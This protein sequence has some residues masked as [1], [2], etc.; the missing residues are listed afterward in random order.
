[1]KAHELS[2][3][4]GRIDDHLVTEA[5]E[6]RRRFRPWMGTVAVAAA[7]CLVVTA[8]LA[9]PGAGWLSGLP[10]AVSDPDN[11]GPQPGGITD[12]VTDSLTGDIPDGAAPTFALAKAV[13]PS[14]MDYPEE[15]YDDQG[16]NVHLEW[17]KERSA[18]REM[19]KDYAD[20]L[21]AYYRAT[22]AQFLS[23]EEGEN[24]VY[25]PLNL[26]IALAMLAETTDGNSRK[27]ILDLLDVAD[28]ETLRARVKGLWNANYQDDGYAASV[29]ANSLW[30][31]ENIEYVQKTLNTIAENYYASTFQGEMGSADYNAALQAW[32]NENTG[33]LLKDQAADIKTDPRT[34]LALASTIYFSGMWAEKFDKDLTKE[35][36]FH[37]ADGDV[38]VDFMHEE[39]LLCSVYYGD[40]Y[41][42]I[43][44]RLL[45]YYSMWLLLPDEGVSL[46]TIAKT[47]DIPGHLTKWTDYESE[48][49]DEH[50]DFYD[51]TLSMPKFDV[52][53]SMDLIDGLKDLGITDV[54]DEAKANFTPAFADSTM[55]VVVSEA[56]HAARVAVDE[57]GCTAAALT[58]I[59]DWGMGAPE[60]KGPL[61][62]N[63]NRP[64]MFLITG[65]DNALL[66][67]G[68]VETPR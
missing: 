23:G 12:D 34:V 51:V 26:Y 35:D 59:M 63:L 11:T 47:G 14:L 2:E 3:A 30:L 48:D 68:A 29:L 16:N 1:M 33:G 7:V 10:D 28:M 36:V 13:Y 18:Q 64:F 49:R 57:D 17:Y 66:F 24:R 58:M 39:K 25:S 32:L 50:W 55:D 31:D 60:S 65:T 9:G 40:G 52:S 22:M 53:D 45:D 61:D 21:E 46:N 67:A 41:K 5:V 27:Q 15:E 6:R 20:G 54:F 62:F 56:T 43:Q 42:A 44:R 37:T 8:V 19:S 4:I 38:T